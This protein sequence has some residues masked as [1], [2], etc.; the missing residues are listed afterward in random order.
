MMSFQIAK[1]FTIDSTLYK[2]ERGL[3]IVIYAAKTDFWQTL[4]DKI[5]VAKS[6]KNSGTIL[7]VK[8]L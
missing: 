6:M 1:G 7:R 3:T 8:F 4:Y 2:G 5:A